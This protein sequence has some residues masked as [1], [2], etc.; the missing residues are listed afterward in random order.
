MY[1]LQSVLQGMYQSIRAPSHAHGCSDTPHCWRASQM[2]SE[3][4]IRV[5]NVY[6]GTWWSL[7]ICNMV[8]QGRGRWRS[9]SIR[10]EKLG[11]KCWHPGHADAPPYARP[12][13]RGQGR[14]IGMATRPCTLLAQ[15]RTCCIHPQQTAAVRRSHEDVIF[16]V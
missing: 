13:R 14:R 2:A 7:S 5:S 3:C 16:L 4:V 12:L 1:S 8:R 15:A 6:S 9:E 10:T 11:E